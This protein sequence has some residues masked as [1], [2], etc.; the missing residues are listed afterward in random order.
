MV[1]RINWIG[2]RIQYLN[3]QIS[4]I[5]SGVETAMT[6][7]DERD[8]L[9]DELS[10]YVKID[11]SEDANHVVTVMM[12]GNFFCDGLSVSHLGLNTIEGP[13]SMYLYGAR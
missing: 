2:D 10:G 6:L 7:R 4:V 5:E 1:D 8:L 12:E 11:Y 3:G 13:H 9:L